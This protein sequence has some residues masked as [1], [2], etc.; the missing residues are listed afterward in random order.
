[1]AWEWHERPRDRYGRFAT[2]H[3]RDQ[4]HLRLPPTQV[5]TIRE[6]ARAA[7]ME[8]SEY[9]WRAVETVTANGQEVATS[10]GAP[11]GAQHARGGESTNSPP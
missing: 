10:G 4:L 5:E 2:R 8:I 7:R 9:I 1:M 6:A 3:K 11:G